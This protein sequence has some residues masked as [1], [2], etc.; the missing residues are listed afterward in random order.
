MAVFNLSNCKLAIRGGLL[1]GIEKLDVWRGGELQLY[2]NGRSADFP[3]AMTARPSPTGARC[4]E[5]IE[6]VVVDSKLCGCLCWAC[7]G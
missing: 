3:P 4:D 2:E 7:C 1:E 6:L 5:G